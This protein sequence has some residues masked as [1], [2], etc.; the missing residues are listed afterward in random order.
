MAQ[1]GQQPRRREMSKR[2]RLSNSSVQC[3]DMFKAIETGKKQESAVREVRTCVRGLSWDGQRKCCHGNEN[4]TIS[5]WSKS[6]RD[7]RIWP[8][9]TAAAIHPT[10]KLW[11]GKLPSHRRSTTVAGAA[12]AS[13]NPAC[14]ADNR[15]TL[16]RA[17]SHA[18]I[19]AGVTRQ[20]LLR[21]SWRFSGS[22]SATLVDAS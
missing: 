7:V 10:R 12:G 17:A 22:F 3:L 21:V 16:P 18:A 6:V 20:F 5:R 15:A 2:L 1:C 11:R 13:C 8:E 4:Y 14:G 19:I 9:A